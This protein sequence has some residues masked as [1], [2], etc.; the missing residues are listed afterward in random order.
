V[1]GLTCLA[2][3]FSSVSEPEGASG[4]TDIINSL[5]RTGQHIVRLMH[6]VE[7]S[8]RSGV[9]KYSIKTM[10][11]K[12]DFLLAVCSI[13]HSCASIP[14]ASG[15]R[16]FVIE[17]ASDLIVGYSRL[18]SRVQNT[19]KSSLLLLLRALHVRRGV[20]G[21]AHVTEIELDDI[22]D[23]LIQLLLGRS[24]CRLVPGEMPEASPFDPLTGEPDDHLYAVYAP[25]WRALL[26]REAQDGDA[27]PSSGG[28]IKNDGDNERRC[29]AAE[30]YSSL[31]RGSLQ[32]LKTLNISY[33]LGDGELDVFPNNLIDQE[34]LLNLASTLE[35][36]FACDV[37]FE[38][39]RDR[40]ISEWVATVVMLSNEYPYVSALY[41]ILRTVLVHS[42]CCSGT[43]ISGG[44]CDISV[45][46]TIR[47]FLLSLGTRVLS[48]Q[49]E[50]MWAALSL[51]LSPPSAVIVG[52]TA[53][54]RAALFAL[55]AGVHAP[56]ALSV[57]E[58]Y[59]GQQELVDD[60][61]QILPQLEK[62]LSGTTAT[63]SA[64]NSSV[65]PGAEGLE[66]EGNV[67]KTVLR[68]LGR[69]GG[70]NKLLLSDPKDA[71][72]SSASWSIGG[73]AQIRYSF[74]VPSAAGVSAVNVEFDR[75][76]PRIVAL[77]SDSSERH[78]RI[79]AAEC[80]HSILLLL[81]GT[82]SSDPS[83]KTQ[84]SADS[85]RYSATYRKI[86]PVSLALAVSAD[87]TC[88]VLFN[89][90]MSQVV[91][92]FSSPEQ[93]P[94]ADFQALLESLM[95]GANEG[96]AAEL[97][98]Y[99]A[100]LL[101]ELF[102]WCLR[103]SDRK[104]STARFESVLQLLEDNARHPVQRNRLGSVSVL[105]RLYVHFR[106]DEAVVAQHTLKILY[107]LIVS[108]RYGHTK[109]CMLLWPSLT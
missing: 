109:V 68:F 81:I 34:M 23:S 8:Q 47:S 72:S 86:F 31:M 74:P 96:S 103:H 66:K 90:L 38:E 92:W 28:L 58:K 102:S 39:M 43:E 94:A 13:L 21:A 100:Q 35:T 65:N 64:V 77:C 52:Y 55:S 2:P 30:V 73:G 107:S 51:L 60:L 14:F 18:W 82:S 40:W 67:Q 26:Q 97:R 19:V 6:G 12:A 53:T 1:K 20:A 69:L 50:R 5:I 9:M 89:M 101:T 63:L 99:C 79:A 7:D 17:Y 61:P 56:A 15:L 46:K 62:F 29:V 71:L 106:E 10:E 45:Q 80:L 104:G 98:D 85:S 36:I 87:K 88:R 25:L 78:I 4:T 93:V 91:H 22:V 84:A 3:S 32:Y 11:R 37:L 24:V 42:Q 105:N 16:A 57:L 54:S 48:F 44:L 83:Y 75:M 27:V 108:L 59:I 95:D 70:Y 41:R 76:V 49:Q 33:T